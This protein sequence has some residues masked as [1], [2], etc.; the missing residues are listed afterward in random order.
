MPPTRLPPPQ[1]WASPRPKGFVPPPSPRAGGGP[2]PFSLLPLTG[3]PPRP[4]PPPPPVLPGPTVFR[5]PGTPRGPEGPPASPPQYPQF[6]GKPPPGPASNGRT[7]RA[8]GFCQRFNPPS[9]PFLFDL[10][11]SHNSGNERGNSFPPAIFRPPFLTA[12]PKIA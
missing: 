8:N 7:P 10:S 1:C 12:R 9:P 11:P 3:P 5:A 2:M 6:A 4:P